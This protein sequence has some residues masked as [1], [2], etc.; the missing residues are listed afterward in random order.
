MGSE[1][2]FMSQ[3]EKYSRLWSPVHFCCTDAQ[4]ASLMFESSEDLVCLQH[5]S[6]SFSFLGNRCLLFFSQTFTKQYT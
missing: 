4:E 3:E 6:L 1:H 2:Y 5:S